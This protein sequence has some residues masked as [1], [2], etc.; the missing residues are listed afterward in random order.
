MRYETK[1]IRIGEWLGDVPENWDYDAFYAKYISQN[2][3]SF[4]RSVAL[5][6]EMDAALRSGKR[7]IATQSGQFS[8]EV[9]KCGLYD[10]WAFWV[11]RPCYSYKGPISGEHIDE[12]YN[13]TSIKIEPTE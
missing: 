7:V 4:D 13:L 11:P 5:F 12:F 3:E 8:H 2:K 6:K 10:G 1:Q 9:Y